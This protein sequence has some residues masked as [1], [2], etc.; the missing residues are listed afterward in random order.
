MDTLHPRALLMV[1]TEMLPVAWEAKVRCKQFW[2]RILMSKVYKG[3]LLRKVA[4]QAVEWG[5]GCW[6]RCIAKCVGKF[7]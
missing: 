7:G 1:E 6:I 4:L 5:K 3:W 2:F